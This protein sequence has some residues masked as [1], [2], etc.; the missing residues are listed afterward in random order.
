MNYLEKLKRNKEG[1]IELAPGHF[2]RE[3]IE[4]DEQKAIIAHCRFKVTREEFPGVERLYS[5]RN[6]IPLRPSLRIKNQAMGLTP[7]ILDLSLLTS[8]GGYHGL[9]LELKRMVT[10][11]PTPEETDWLT[12]L[13][14][15]GFAAFVAHGRYEAWAII[16][17]YMTG[18]FYPRVAPTDEAMKKFGKTLLTQYPMN[19]D[20][21]L[22]DDSKQNDSKQNNFKQPYPKQF[23]ATDN[24]SKAT[25]REAGQNQ[26]Q[27]QN[28][29][30]N[31]GTPEEGELDPGTVEPPPPPET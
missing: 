9:Q 4:D 1:L 3:P 15:E 10:G 31:Q 29:N 21:S 22:Q 24:L 26:G 5:T 12:H 14:Q 17:W 6:G 13:T 2:I 19:L 27:G 30:Q 28:E 8:R 11:S 16:R 23:Y 18:A 25:P 7:G 20:F